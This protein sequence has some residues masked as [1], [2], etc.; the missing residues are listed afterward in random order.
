MSLTEKY[1][2]LLDYARK[3]GAKLTKVEEQ[4][5]VLHIEGSAG[6]LVKDKM[7]DLYNEIDPDMRSGDVVMAIETEGSEEIYEVKAGDSLSKIAT[8]Y[9]GMTW[10]KI[11][12]A[13][14]DKLKDPNIIHP[15]LKLIIP[16]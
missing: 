3:S 6:A 11:Y 5:G 2:K 15:G 4:N 8:K 16:L 7:W 9:P 1:A 12:E 14:K 10:K 13:N